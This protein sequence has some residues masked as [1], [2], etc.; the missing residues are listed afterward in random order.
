[1][2]VTAGSSLP[3]GQTI[4]GSSALDALNAGG[5]DFARGVGA[6]WIGGGQPILAQNSN[7]GPAVPI[8]PG[9]LLTL[10]F[11]LSGLWAI[12]VRTK[13]GPINQTAQMSAGAGRF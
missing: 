7:Q 5:A 13:A 6:Q 3:A 9:Q 2:P 1:M 8:A 4:Q 11:D 10:E 12:Q